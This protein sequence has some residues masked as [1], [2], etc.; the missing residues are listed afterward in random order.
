[1]KLKLCKKNNEWMSGIYR[2][3]GGIS[4]LIKSATSKN[5]FKCLFLF[6]NIKYYYRA[7]TW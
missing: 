3:N 6:I 1:M 4:S 7:L 2:G 5:L